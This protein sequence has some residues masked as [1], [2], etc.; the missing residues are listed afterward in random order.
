MLE[1]GAGFGVDRLH[2]VRVGL[3]DRGRRGDAVEHLGTAAIQ[4]GG[5]PR[6]GRRGDDGGGSDGGTHGRP[7]SSTTKWNV[8]FR[9]CV[10]DSPTS[11]GSI[12]WTKSARLRWSRW[13]AFASRSRCLN[14][15]SVSRGNPGSA[16]L[17]R[18]SGAM[19]T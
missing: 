15:G 8:A 1:R 16:W 6:V 18:Q 5:Q 14:S 7:P 11:R 17:L 3:P 19:N 9:Y 12:A 4:E 13:R 10:S 2:V